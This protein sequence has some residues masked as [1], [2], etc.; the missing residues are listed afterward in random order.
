M[1]RKR[2]TPW[3]VFACLHSEGR[4]PTSPQNTVESQGAGGT[5]TVDKSTFETLQSDLQE[6]LAHEKA[7]TEQMKALEN[8]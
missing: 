8:K 6:K 4:D 7:K 1:G 2:K 5:E 3:K